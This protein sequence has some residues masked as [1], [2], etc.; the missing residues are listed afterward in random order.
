MIDSAELL[1]FINQKLLAGKGT[2]L[3]EQSLLFK[4]RRLDSITILSLIGYLEKKLGRKLRD[5]EISLQNFES[6][7][8]IASSFTIHAIN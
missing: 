6:V 8:A 4:D 2:K 7:R 5:E 3:T 1:I